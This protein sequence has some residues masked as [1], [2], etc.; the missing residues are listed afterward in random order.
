MAGR[1]GNKG[2]V[3]L[4][5][6]EE[7]MPYLPN[8]EPIDILLNPLGVPSRMNLGQILEM[9]LGMAAKELGVYMATPVFDG[10]T[11]PEIVDALKEAGCDED[12]KTELYDGRTGEKFDNRISVG[13]MYFIKLHHMVDD[14]LHARSTG[15]YSLVTQQPLGGKAQFGGQRFGEMEVWALYAYGAAHVLQE[16]ITTKSDDVVGRVKVYEALVKGTPLPKSGVPESFRVLIKEFQALGLDI[17]VLNPEGKFVDFKEIE[18][19]EDDS[20]LNTDEVDSDIPEEPN[21]PDSDY[22]EEDDF[23][24]DLDSIDDAPIE[25]LE[26]MEGAED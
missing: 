2:V 8:G 15:P 24:N 18:A 25:E 10:A 23:D 4:I 12:G 11:V 3:S 13:V 17:T 5:L 14:K 1:H 20:Y 21:E 22:T 9:H 16:M 26:A 19:A 7:D 6:P